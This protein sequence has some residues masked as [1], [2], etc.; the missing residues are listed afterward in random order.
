MGETDYPC[1]GSTLLT[2]EIPIPEQTKKTSN[3]SDKAK[4]VT[5]HLNGTLLTEKIPE[6]HPP[7][8][9]KPIV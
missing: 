5:S 1:I 3:G 9:E 4:L 6:T 2:G 8:E 7:N